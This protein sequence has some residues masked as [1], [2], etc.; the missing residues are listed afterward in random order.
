M[1]NSFKLEF[2]L[3]FEQPNQFSQTDL[4]KHS[5]KPVWVQQRARLLEFRKF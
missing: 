1:D 5:L 2:E 4:Q 3:Q